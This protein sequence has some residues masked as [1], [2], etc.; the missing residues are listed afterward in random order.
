MLYGTKILEVKCQHERKLSVAELRMLG[1][2]YGKT[3]SNRIMNDSI[4]ESWGNTY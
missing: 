1:W 3:R 2:M 4:G